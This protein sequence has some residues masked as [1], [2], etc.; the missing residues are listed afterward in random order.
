[1]RFGG[2]DLAGFHA[3]LAGAGGQ[4][5]DF[6]RRVGLLL[7][8]ARGVGDEIAFGA[9][10]DVEGVF[11]V[12]AL[13]STPARLRRCLLAI[14]I[15]PLLARSLATLT[16]RICASSTS[17]RR[18]GP[19]ASM[20]SR[21]ILPAR[22]LMLEKKTS[23]NVSVD[24]LERQRQLVLLDMAQQRLDRTGI[25][26]AQILEGEHQGLDAFGAVAAAF[27]QRGDEAA[28]GLAVE[29][30]EDFGH[31]L[32]RVALGGAREVGHELDAQGLLDLVENVLL[33][34]FPCAA[35]AARLRARIP[36]AAT[37]STRAACS[38]LILE[39]TTET[40]CGYSFF[41]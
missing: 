18:T 17:L 39:S 3:L 13:I 37:P 19:M 27:F 10:L 32:V 30:V 5:V 22:S 7:A 23:R 40:V 12:P 38:G 16:M 11:A 31:L 2:A 25:E 34:R 29:I 36:R 20:S 14:M 41:R 6:L 4:L 21:R 26:L 28:F 1:M 15:S 24:A 33:H 9:E 35:C 8:R